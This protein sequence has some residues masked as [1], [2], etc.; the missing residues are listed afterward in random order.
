VITVPTVLVV[1]NSARNRRS[2]ADALSRSGHLTVEAATRAE[3]ARILAVTSPDLIVSNINAY[4]KNCGRPRRSKSTANGFRT[5]LYTDLYLTRSD[6]GISG[7]CAPFAEL[8]EA[9]EDYLIAEA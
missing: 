7:E 8:I 1:D 2:V 9:V 3:V 5:V 4:D 6:L